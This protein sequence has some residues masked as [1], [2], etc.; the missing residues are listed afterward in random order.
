M[1]AQPAGIL[2]TRLKPSRQRAFELLPNPAR[3]QVTLRLNSKSQ[4]GDWQVQIFSLSGGLMQ[5][6]T[7]A[8]SATEW[9]FSVQDWPSGMYVVRLMNGPKALS[10]TFVVLNYAVQVPLM[11]AQGS[12]PCAYYSVG[13][14]DKV[15][16]RTDQ[17]VGTR[18][19]R[20]PAEFYL[21]N[22]GKEIK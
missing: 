7:L 21:L 1:P 16:V 19:S 15:V 5:Q 10:Q 2:G 9:A 20:A 12:A 8:A 14:A 17:I 6:N 4:Q 22:Y 3:D 18:Q 13:S 11:L